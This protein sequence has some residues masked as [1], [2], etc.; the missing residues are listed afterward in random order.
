MC[1]LHLPLPLAIIAW[2]IAGF[3]IVD[4]SVSVVTLAL[5]IYDAV[6]G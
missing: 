4:G 3:V 1:A 5:A 2:G 6:K